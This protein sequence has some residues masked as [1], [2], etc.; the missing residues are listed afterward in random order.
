VLYDTQLSFLDAPCTV[1]RWH[2]RLSP[3]DSIGPFDRGAYEA[4]LAQWPRLNG[5]GRSEDAAIEALGD[6]LRQLVDQHAAVGGLTA[7]GQALCAAERLASDQLARW[8][9]DRAEEL[10][11]AEDTFS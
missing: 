10:I 6:R 1:L 11:L 8:L 7:V 3:P 5:W 4:A 9:A 2:P